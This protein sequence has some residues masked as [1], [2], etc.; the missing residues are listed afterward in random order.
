MSGAAFVT[1]IAASSGLFAIGLF[2]LLLRRTVILQL[3]S[4]E[5]MLAAGGFAFV[6]AGARHGGAEGQGMFVLVLT[7]AAAEAAV[8]LVL[9]L[10]LRALADSADSDAFDRLRG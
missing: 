7:V 8:A 6:V 4:L 1:L 5:L 9:F 10:R 3:V 2:G